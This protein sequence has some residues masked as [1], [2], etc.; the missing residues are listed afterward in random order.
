ME[1]KVAVEEDLGVIA[2]D[3]Q[4]T[5]Y[6][7]VNLTEEQLPAAEAVVISGEDHNLMDQA[8]VKTEAPVINARGKTAEEVK[9]TLQK[10]IK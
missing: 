7:V 9:T 10:K 8:D 6:E 1:P 5:G 2:Q 4:T 3:L